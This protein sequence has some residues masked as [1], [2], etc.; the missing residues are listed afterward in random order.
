MATSTDFINY[1]TEQLSLLPQITVK[2]MFG[3]YAIYCKEKVIALVCDNQFFL[4]QTNAGKNILECVLE[5]PPYIGAKPHY[6]IENLDDKEML[7]DLIVA[8]YDEL[9]MPKKKIKKE[10]K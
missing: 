10:I 6:L 2:K 7:R 9:P 1:I 5:S 4:K 3:E 8:T